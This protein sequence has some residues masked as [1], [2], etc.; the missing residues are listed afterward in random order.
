MSLE[1]VIQRILEQGSA[2]A[3]AVA[4]AARKEMEGR[5]HEIQEKGQGDIAAKTADGRKATE[6]LRTQE[7]ARA[8]LESRK[9]V[10]A[11][12]RETLDAVRA[13]VLERVNARG[14]KEEILRSLLDSHKADWKNGKVFCNAADK[15]RVKS[16]VGSRFGGT[17]QCS[18]GLVIEFED[19]TGRIDL[20]FEI[21]LQDIWEDSVKEIAEMLWPRH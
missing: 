10:L 19:G 9:I 20:R 18:G 7:T 14:I 15:D 17:I 16:I 1:A 21:L 8:E 4:D 6:K 11:G 5:L 2:E 13:E 12:Q 3:R